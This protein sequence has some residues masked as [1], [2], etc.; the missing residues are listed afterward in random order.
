MLLEAMMASYLE[1]GKRK[2]NLSLEYKILSVKGGSS[3][4][5]VIDHL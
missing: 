3:A 2:P 1:I 5:D 4:A